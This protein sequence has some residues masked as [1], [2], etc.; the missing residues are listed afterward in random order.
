MYDGSMRT[1]ASD[2]VEA[3]TNVKRLSSAQLMQFAVHADFCFIPFWY[4]FF[5]PHEEFDQSYPVA[6]HSTTD[7]GYL[8]VIAYCFH[9]RYRRIAFLY[10]AAFFEQREYLHVG[11][12]WAD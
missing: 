2:G 7:A 8:D 6:L 9:S 3:F 12:R 1:I 10:M 11:L 5:Q 4:R